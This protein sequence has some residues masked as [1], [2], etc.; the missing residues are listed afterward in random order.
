MSTI[1]VVTDSAACLPPELV[2]QYDIHVVPF[3]LIWDE[4]V[5]RDGVDLTSEEFYQRFR[6]VRSRPTTSQPSLADFV[7]LYARLSQEVEGIVS[8]HIPEE[9]SGTLAAAR[10]AAKQ[11]ATVPIQVMDARTATIAEGFIV[12]AAARAAKA[13][14]NLEKVVAAA[15]AM[16]PRVDFFATLATLEHLH[17][18]GRIGEAVALVGSRLRI[19]PILNLK[20]ARVKVVSVVRSRRRAIERILELVEAQVGKRPIHASVFHADALDEAKRMSEEVFSRFNCVEFYITEFTPVMGAHTGPG[21][22]G[23]AFYTGE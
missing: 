17:R 22:V 9:L 18:G 14:G 1:A 20:D 10:L 3:E 6:Q 11:A 12:L 5:Y 4:R 16:I 7:R 2:Q 8:I 21:V 23:L 15:E 19:N 13:G